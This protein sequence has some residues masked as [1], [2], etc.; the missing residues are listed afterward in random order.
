MTTRQKSYS[1]VE[2]REAQKFRQ[3]WM[4]LILGIT[5]LI[6]VYGIY[7]QLIMGEPFG[8]N[9]APDY[10]LIIF[11]IFIFGLLLLLW[12]VSLETEI[13]REA[14]R[15][16]FRPFLRKTFNWDDIK[17]A[18]IVNYG[19]QG[20]WGIRIW[21][22]F[23]TLYNVKGNKGLAIEMNNGKKYCIG[24]QEEDSLARI[25]EKYRQGQD[26]K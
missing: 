17:S 2:F 22:K 19:F 6:P 15:I 10:I 5:G 16:Y 20:G 13:D 14:I 8:N 9:P 26:S 4:W 1:R 18:G 23:G 25:L 3:W 21:T 24:T 12:T 7:K 11:A